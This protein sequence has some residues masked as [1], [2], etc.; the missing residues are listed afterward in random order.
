MRTSVIFSLIVGCSLFGACK[1]DLQ[2]GGGGGTNAGGW[3]SVGGG[4]SGGSGGASSSIV[5]CKSGYGVN[6]ATGLCI[7][8]AAYDCAPC[9]AGTSTSTIANGTCCGTC[10]TAMICP[11]GD[12]KA[13]NEDSA[14]GSI[15]GKCNAD[16]TCT[17]KAGSTL[18][19]T[20][21]KCAI[22]CA[23]VN[24]APCPSPS[25]HIDDGTCCGKCVEPAKVCVANQDCN[26]DPRLSSFMGTCN[27]DGTCTCRAGATINPT[28]G[29]C[30]SECAIIACAPCAPGWN[31]VTDGTCCGTCIP[32]TAVTVAE[33]ELTRLGLKGGDVLSSSTITLPAAFTD[34]NWGVKAEACK[35]GGWDLTPYAGTVVQLIGLSSN[36]VCAD[37]TAELWV[38]SQEDKVICDYAS[39]PSATPGICPVQVAQ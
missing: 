30:I 33:A 18:S 37:A 2:V 5:V 36:A 22:D 7:D 6:P 24:C 32:S 39:V 3:A 38:M 34:P 35:Q 31:A 17:C 29:K 14:A 28:T 19:A 21:G 8:C 9:P 13:C 11:P 20:S 27:A 26:D 4:G 1:V 25:T 10:S 15:L 16:S 12:D 23:V